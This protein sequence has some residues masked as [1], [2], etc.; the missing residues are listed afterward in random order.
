MAV[1][2]DYVC[3]C[4]QRTELRVEVS[5]RDDPRSCP[6]CG[7]PLKRTYCAPGLVFKGTGWGASKP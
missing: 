6:T 5:E 7:Q 2:Y 1:T 4:E 3:G